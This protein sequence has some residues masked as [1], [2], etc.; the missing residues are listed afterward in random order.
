MQHVPIRYLHARHLTLARAGFHD[1]T[2][3]ALN[4]VTITSHCTSRPITDHDLRRSLLWRRESLAGCACKQGTR[5]SHVCV[6]PTDGDGSQ[7][8]PQRRY[9]QLLSVCLSV[10]LSFCQALQYLTNIIDLFLSYRTDSTD[11]RTI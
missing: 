2:F 5:V 11:S 10:C 8:L 6:G 1:F 9:G 3:E 4:L 7:S